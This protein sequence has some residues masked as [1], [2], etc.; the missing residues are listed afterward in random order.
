MVLEKINILYPTEDMNRILIYM[1]IGISLIR[2]YLNIDYSDD[3]I[4]KKFENA[5]IL[6]LINSIDY[7]KDKGISTKKQGNKSITYTNYRRG[8]QLTSDIK[9]L[10]P[11]PSI[12]VM[13]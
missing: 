1:D 11:S 5:L 9:D 4:E 8:L 13:G 3:K 10:L 2:E 12:R 7:S 6:F